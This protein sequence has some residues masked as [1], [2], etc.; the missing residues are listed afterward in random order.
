MRFKACFALLVLLLQTQIAG[1]A[2]AG[3]TI[4][5]VNPLYTPGELAHQLKD[6]GAK[7]IVLLENMAATFAACRQK[8]DVEH[9]VVTAMGDL[10]PFLKGTIVNFVVRR[11][12]KMVPAFDLPGSVSFKQ[13]R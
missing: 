2:M 7:A 6:S 13:A 12:K 10:L 5:N 3:L 11:V 4:V 8:T 1:A 9:V